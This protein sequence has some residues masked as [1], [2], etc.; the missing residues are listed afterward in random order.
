M[1]YL[2]NVYY[3]FVPVLGIWVVGKDVKDGVAY[4]VERLICGILK[5][6]TPFYR[7]CRLFKG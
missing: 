1:Y 2:R 6:T 4:F 7:Y 5:H 3:G